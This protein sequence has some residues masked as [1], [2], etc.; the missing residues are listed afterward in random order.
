MEIYRIINLIMHAIYLPLNLGF[1]ILLF[2]NR[3]PSP[4]WK[5][6][7]AVVIGL[8]IMTSTRFVDSILYAFYPNNTLY[9][10]EVYL[11]LIST[12]VATA[13]FLFW[14]LFLAG[15][16]YVAEK[17]SFRIFIFAISAF[18]C[19]VVGTNSYTNL[20]YK[21]VEMGKEHIHGI[22]WIPCFLVVYGMLFA[23]WLISII[24]IL[25][26]GSE[27]IKRIIIFSLYPFGPA[28]AGLVR[29]IT[30]VD[31]LDFTPVVMTVSVF[32]MYSIIFKNNYVNVVPQSMEEA[33]NHTE[34][35]LAVFSA[36]DGQIEYCNK[37]AS[38]KY[39]DTLAKIKKK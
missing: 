8:W 33:L 2:R 18:V 5:W 19:V 26:E 27:R 11:Q 9:R 23:G 7:A 21:Q 3:Q 38:E 13:S 25:R 36:F 37:S 30:K 34:S 28:L 20:F 22:L 24:N 35:G 16:Y 12:T 1:I 6:F 10:C 4:I 15:K 14:N 39:I 31:E 32:C 17:K 29:S